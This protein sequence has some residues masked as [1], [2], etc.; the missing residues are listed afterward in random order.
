[1]LDRQTDKKQLR[2]TLR[3]ICDLT[4]PN[5]PRL[6]DCRGEGRQNRSIPVLVT[7]WQD[8]VPVVEETTTALT[9]DISDSGVSLTLPGPFRVHEIAIGFWVPD[10]N[11]N[12]HAWFLLGVTRES[13]P[14]G[15]GFWGLGVDTVRPLGLSEVEELVPM[16]E[17]RLPPSRI[18]TEPPSALIKD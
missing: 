11:Y 18:E 1:M 14:I 13:V 10:D 2:A 8:G 7:P 15:G 3:R 6:D 12:A 17:K 9:K 4:S 5:L 16:V